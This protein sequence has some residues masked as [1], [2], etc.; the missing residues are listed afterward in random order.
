[1]TATEFRPVAAPAAASGCSEPLEAALER[2][3]FDDEG[4][5]EEGDDYGGWEHPAAVP[6]ASR[7][8]RPPPGFAAPAAG[9]AA[10]L[11]ALHHAF[12][13]YSL[14]DLEDILARSGG[15]LRA[16][17]ET[18]WRLESEIAGMHAARAPAPADPA[19]SRAL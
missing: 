1:M 6:P 8:L 5:W 3:H 10:D 4:D 11:A 15:S 16:A 13:A 17:Q 2:L 9:D 7:P 19:A 18:L 14:Y 12:P